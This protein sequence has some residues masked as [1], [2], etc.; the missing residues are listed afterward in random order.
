MLVG[1]G[2]LVGDF[3]ATIKLVG[4]MIDALCLSSNASLEYRELVE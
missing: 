4:T 2:F 1:F 3:I